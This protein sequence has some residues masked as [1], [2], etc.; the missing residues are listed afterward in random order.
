[1]DREVVRRPDGSQAVRDYLRHPAAVAIV[2]LTAM[3][4]MKSL[5]R[6]NFLAYSRKEATKLGTPHFRN[7]HKEQW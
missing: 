3:N 7:S 1:M 6:S 2:A 5:K 4:V